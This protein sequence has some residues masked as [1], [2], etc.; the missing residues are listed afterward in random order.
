MSVWQMNDKMYESR[1]GLRAWTERENRRGTISFQELVSLVPALLLKP[2]PGH[3][4]IDLCAAPGNKSVQ[5]LE[6][7]STNTADGSSSCGAVL[8]ADADGQRCCLALARVLSQ[9]AS[10]S[11]CSV[12]ANSKD[13]PVLMDPD[14]SGSR[15]EFSRI[16]ADVPCSGDGTA[17]KNTQIWRSWKRKEALSLFSL[18]RNLLLRGM[19]LLPPGGLLVYSTCSLNPVENEAVVHSALMKWQKST[20]D[21]EDRRNLSIELEDAL[22]AC[23]MMCDLRP[24]EGLRTWLVPSPKRGGPIFQTWDEVP[25][26]LCFSEQGL[27]R[28]DM[29]P[30]AA[31]FPDDSIFSIALHRCA[32]FYPQ[33]CDT[34]GFFVAMLRKSLPTTNVP[35]QMTTTSQQDV[36]LCR[37]PRQH[38]LL[39]SSFVPVGREDTHWRTLVE[40]FGID[41]SWAKEQQAQGLLF[42]QRINGRDEPERLSLVSEDVARLWRARPSKG[43]TLAWVRLGTFLFEQ[44]PKKFLKGVAVTRWR[45]TMEG[46]SFLAQKIRQR[47]LY[48]SSDKVLHLLHADNRQVLVEDLQLTLPGSVVDD[49]QGRHICGAVLIGAHCSNGSQKWMPGV[50]TPQHVRL[51]V[52]T[53]VAQCLVEDFTHEFAPVSSVSSDIKSKGCGCWTG[54]SQ[55]ASSCIHLLTFGSR[56]YT[57]T[58]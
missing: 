32:R 40:F 8:S 19:Y 25:A 26:E 43:N 6:A 39:H 4:C 14:G 22:A 17:R 50:L 34:G 29:F 47:C 7:L 10:P 5:L 46:A 35:R 45:P 28:P 51:L 48:L 16:L 2:K 31:T 23:S 49:A 1:A 38:P 33:H 44:L 11:S 56:A 18:Q 3:L 20:E 37:G 21:P 52:D 42:W 36:P 24:S 57:G 30:P 54:I 15:I 12:L 55:A 58:S 13:F 41:T 27:V 9:A 53:D